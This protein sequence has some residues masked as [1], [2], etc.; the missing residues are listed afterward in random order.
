MGKSKKRVLAVAFAWS[1][2]H[3]SE[4]A[5]GWNGVKMV[6]SFADVVVLTTDRYQKETEE[7]LQ[8][9]CED[10]TQRTEFHFIKH[11]LDCRLLDRLWPPYN[12]WAYKYWLTKSYRYATRLQK[13]Y[14][15]DACHLMTYVTFR[16]PGSFYKLKCPFVWGPIGALENTPWH[17]LPIMGIKGFIHFACRNV[18]N[19][20]HKKF[21]SAP[22]KALQ[23]ASKKGA[24]ISATP[25][26]QKEI[27]RWYQIDS[28]VICEVTAPE[29]PEVS[30]S[31]RRGMEPLRICW[32]GLHNPAKALHL[33]LEA[34]APL[35]VDVAYELHI[36]GAGGYTKKWKTLA[37]QLKINQY[38]IWHG[39]CSREEALSVMRESH[40][41]VITSLKD[42][43]STVL[44]EALA[45]GLPVL[46]PDLCGFPG[47]VDDGCGKV[48]PIASVSDF[49]AE[50]REEILYLY[51][52][53]T[54]RRQL[55]AGAIAKAA[56]Y[57][58]ESK[59][60]KYERI[61]QSV[62]NQK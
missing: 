47:V 16:Y 10:W 8:E 3:G 13:K 12:I 37:N 36:L 48:L 33:L 2:Y 17:L 27:Q 50:L 35:Q 30:P 38:C 60:E 1:P 52:N 23:I 41:F 22:K 51:Q 4:C 32:S 59:R 45:L 6:A 56:E 28:N 49:I 25:A 20:F 9:S 58:W 11:D 46:C 26:I 14:R 34:L 7:Y 55:A 54:K 21:L 62:W 43:T 61:Y 39:L 29:M 53:E 18:I 42:L 57:N 44:L 31:I 15:F 40:L 24:V 5:V 19:N